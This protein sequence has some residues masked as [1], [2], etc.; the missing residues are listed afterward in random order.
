VLLAATLVACDA[1]GDAPTPTTRAT[2]TPTATTDPDREALVA[3]A[4]EDP[5]TLVASVVRSLDAE[6]VEVATDGSTYT[7]GVRRDDRNGAWQVALDAP[8]GEAVL[9]VVGGQLC[10]DRAARPLLRGLLQSSY[11]RSRFDTQPWTCTPRAFGLNDALLWG[12]LRQDPRDRVETL[13]TEPA[14]YAAAVT[15]LDGRPVLHV[16]TTGLTEEGPLDPA[17]PEYEL[18]LDADRL[19]LRMR[20]QG[21]TWEFAYRTARDAP[22]LPARRDRGSYGYAVG[23]GQ[24][25]VKACFYGGVCPP[26]PPLVWGDGRIAVDVPRLS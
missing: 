18:W 4:A 25:A 16:R 22:V 3:L 14:T 26:L 8:A 7:Y 21:R 13:S 19:P 12:H 5:A 1:G 24:G 11:G 17:R 20:S 23:P 6:V 9:R 10:F 2:P 15:D